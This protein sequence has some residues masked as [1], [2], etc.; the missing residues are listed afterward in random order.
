MAA[1]IVR[2]KGLQAA[3]SP[4]AAIKD[5]A[6]VSAWAKAYVNT[7]YEQGF[8]LGSNGFFNPKDAVTREMAAVVLVRLYENN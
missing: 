2:L 8:M 6:E 4:Q 5:R 1:V 7:A 3:N